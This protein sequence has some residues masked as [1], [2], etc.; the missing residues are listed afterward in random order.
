MV[1]LGMSPRQRQNR[2]KQPVF[3]AMAAGE[4]KTRVKSRD[5]KFLVEYKIRLVTSP[6]YEEIS[7]DR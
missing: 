1:S 5:K 2:S 4:H 3:R 7:G 6:L